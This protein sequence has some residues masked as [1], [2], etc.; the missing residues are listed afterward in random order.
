MSNTVSFRH[1][2]GG[3]TM[4]RRREIG[5]I[6]IKDSILPL[7]EYRFCPKCGRMYPKD[8]NYCPKENEAIKLLKIKIEL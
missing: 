3:I 6:S 4:I 8:Y 7:G 1:S 2:I 5:K